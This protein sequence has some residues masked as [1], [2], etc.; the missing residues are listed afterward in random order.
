MAANGSS[1]DP[2]RMATTF[3]IQKGHPGRLNPIHTSRM[4]RKT[5]R[6]RRPLVS[7]ALRR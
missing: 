6:Q 4:L 5:A 2:A 7:R 1:T 3:A